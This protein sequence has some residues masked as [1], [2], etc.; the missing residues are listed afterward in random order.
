VFVKTNI[1]TV[2]DNGL[3]STHFTDFLQDFFHC[4]NQ[5]DTQL[6]G[7]SDTDVY[8]RKEEA[9]SEMLCIL[10]VGTMEKVL[11]EVCEVSET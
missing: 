8:L 1:I 5:Q 4:P 9:S 7:R 6:F 3:I 11:K 2:F 10:L